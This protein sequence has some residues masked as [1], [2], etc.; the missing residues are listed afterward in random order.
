MYVPYREP[1]MFRN[2]GCA[3]VVNNSKVNHAG[4]FAR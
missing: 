4:A 1:L 3:G 2:V